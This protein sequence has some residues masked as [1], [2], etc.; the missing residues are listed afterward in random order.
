MSSFSLVNSI[1]KALDP[2]FVGEFQNMK[3]SPTERDLDP[4]RVKHLKEKAEAGV[5]VTFNWA[6]ARLNGEWLR[7]NGQHSSAMLANLNGEFPNNLIVHLDE[8]E[9]DSPEGLALLFRQY[10]DR[11][12]GRSPSDVSGAYQGLYEPLHDVPKDM[13]KI[14]IEGVVW[15][16]R[17]IEG[18]PVPSGD[19]QYHMFNEVGL[20]TYVKWAAEVFGLKT[21]ELKRVSILSSMYATFITNELEAKAFW[22]LVSRGGKE[23]EDAHPATTISQW[24]Q[25]AYARE[26]KKL[27]KPGEFY[28]A[29]VYAWN[30]YR[31]DKT[32]TSIKFDTKKALLTPHA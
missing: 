29:C 14:A 11:K 5:L 20:Y 16:R 30:A 9:V 28:Q 2:E 12:S 18:M 23:Y 4:K 32:I 3:P 25:K 27:P 26:F 10:D 31:E 22:Y 19:D 13:A 21:P 7:M 1:S 8:Y 17:N 24:L 15:Y 6:R